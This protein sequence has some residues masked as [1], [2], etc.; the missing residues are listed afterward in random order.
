VTTR[1]EPLKR[2]NQKM[3]NTKKQQTTEKTKPVHK[4]RLGSI[5]VSIWENARENG[6][7]SYRAVVVKTYRDQK[8]NW[9]ETN[10]FRA[11]DLVLVSTVAQRAADWM[12]DR[13]NES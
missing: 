4:I 2:R 6:K 7:T 8:G 3:N 9:Q 1:G 13:E 11:D 5:S 10:S 12:L